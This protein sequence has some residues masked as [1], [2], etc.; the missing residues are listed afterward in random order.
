MSS[1]IQRI[2]RSQRIQQLSP[3]VQSSIR[4]HAIVSSFASIV[5]QLIL[6]ALD[7]EATS[8][9]V[10]I[11]FSKKAVQV[12]DN[13]VGLS[14]EEISML[15]ESNASTK[16]LYHSKGTYGSRG[17][18]LASIVGSTES[19]EIVS[20]TG[21]FQEEEDAP[22]F[23]NPCFHTNKKSRRKQSN[24]VVEKVFRHGKL[25]KA[26]S[27][28]RQRLRGTSVTV[29]GI[30]CSLPVRSRSLRTDEELKVI[31]H[32]TESISMLHP[33]VSFSFKNYK[34]GKQPLVLEPTTNT[35][36]RFH[37]IYGKINI[38]PLQPFLEE[39]ERPK[40]CLRGFWAVA[41]RTNVRHF[42]VNGVPCE[43]RQFGEV[44]DSCATKLNSW[45]RTKKS[46]RKKY[47]LMCVLE[48]LCGTTDY[49][50]EHG[51]TTQEV[52]FADSQ[53]LMQ[54]LTDKLTAA[55]R[56]YTE[57]VVGEDDTGSS[58]SSSTAE[59]SNEY[60]TQKDCSDIFASQ[61]SS[62]TS[63][64]EET[65]SPLVN[66]FAIGASSLSYS[67]EGRELDPFFAS[68][69][70]TKRQVA[71]Q[72][73]APKVQKRL[74][75][76]DF[77]QAKEFPPVYDRTQSKFFQRSSSTV[78]AAPSIH[79][80]STRAAPPTQLPQHFRFSLQK[81]NFQS[82]RVLGQLDLKFIVCKAMLS[83]PHEVGQTFRA[84]SAFIA[85]DQ[86]AADERIRVEE[87]EKM[88]KEQLRFGSG[89]AKEYLLRC[90]KLD[91]CHPL[92]LSAS[93]YTIVKTYAE[94]FKFWGWHWH[95]E[96]DDASFRKIALTHTPSLVG[97]L[98][99][100]QDFYDYLEKLK[101]LLPPKDAD[102]NGLSNRHS[103]SFVKRILNSKACRGAIMFGDILS[104]DA[105]RR[106]VSNLEQCQLP[107]QC[108]HGRPS[109]S[110]LL[111]LP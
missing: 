90:I 41:S 71:C 11:D 103:P 25:C 20:T 4:C 16:A 40:F 34:T 68:P 36:T 72:P 50:I 95:V 99:G 33:E 61:F 101:H 43:S 64:F 67:G 15:G 8:I 59:G 54:T 57:N 53:F 63:E 70:E 37:Q 80:I 83:M 24:S 106:L 10:V 107:F 58:V 9:G 97:E 76:N 79:K 27:S 7:A 91:E 62:S 23:T 77:I 26:G 86:H 47:S 22:G 100:E 66:N 12:D 5:E 29:R 51:G 32:K 56:N 73:R 75:Y 98:T 89:N 105:M 82:L 109:I 45:L 81:E 87:M 102:L 78:L 39:C 44:L 18:T 31:L 74:V 60:E 19:V 104:T 96:Y 48:V 42:Y 13:G 17:E 84:L 88:L 92:L 46:P 30:Y 35:F 94:M 55:I 93:D 1:S 38:T 3:G 110:P 28:A 2:S 108:A 21:E 6:N 49:F 52:Y 69:L 65:S 14:S 111:V 85:I